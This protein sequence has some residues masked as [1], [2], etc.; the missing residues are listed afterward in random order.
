MSRENSSHAYRPTA[1]MVCAIALLAAQTAHAADLAIPVEREE[2]TAESQAQ[3]ESFA[4]DYNELFPASGISLRTSYSRPGYERWTTKQAQRF[5]GNLQKTAEGAYEQLGF[6][7][8]EQFD[9][10]NSSG[11]YVEST[12]HRLSIENGKIALHAIHLGPNNNRNVYGPSAVDRLGNGLV[13]KEASPAGVAIGNWVQST[14]FRS[15]DGHLG[16]V[17]HWN[18]PYVDVW[19]PEDPPLAEKP[20]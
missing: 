18:A 12:I 20:Q 3:L 15:R 14:F 8:T 9:T 5:T 4:H 10:G 2:N 1:M 19:T 13:F 7:D 11:M 6:C 17:R 16:S